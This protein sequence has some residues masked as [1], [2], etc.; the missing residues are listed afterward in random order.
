MMVME[1]LRKVLEFQDHKIVAV[2]SS[3]KTLYTTDMIY[4]VS[5]KKLHFLSLQES[6]GVAC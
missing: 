3:V 4:T 5:Q 2:L 1:Y 6:D